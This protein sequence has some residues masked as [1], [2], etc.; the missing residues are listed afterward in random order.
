[1]FTYIVKIEKEREELTQQLMEIKGFLQDLFRNYQGRDTDRLETVLKEKMLGMFEY[2]VSVDSVGSM[3]MSDTPS[4]CSFFIFLTV[5]CDAYDQYLEY[6][7]Q[8]KT[9]EM[10]EKKWCMFFVEYKELTTLEETAACQVSKFNL[11]NLPGLY[12]PNTIQAKI[13]KFL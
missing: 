1:M 6:L 2:L 9:K 3:W 13:K 4:K 7:L 5:R 11:H 12:L 8:L 10:E